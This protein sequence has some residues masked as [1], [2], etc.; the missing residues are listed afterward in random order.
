MSWKTG[1]MRR[2]EKIVQKFDDSKIMTYIEK[3]VRDA[4]NSASAEISIKSKNMVEE[5]AHRGTLQSGVFS[6]S[7]ASLIDTI[8]TESCKSI[9]KTVEDLQYK[10]HITYSQKIIGSISELIKTSYQ[11]LIDSAI[12]NDYEKVTLAMKHESRS[13]ELQF[14]TLRQKINGMV[15]G[16][17]QEIQLDN[18][19]K[20]DEPGVRETRKSNII[21][22]LTLIVSVMTFILSWLS[23]YLNL[24]K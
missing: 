3:K 6:T 4:T 1:I 21:A 10:W 23:L 9:L 7:I 16:K 13:V 18:K 24:K 14:N 11:G 20:K 8:I 5:H 19:V 12:R 22:I 2:V 17:M 15:D